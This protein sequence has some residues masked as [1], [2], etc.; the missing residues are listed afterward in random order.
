MPPKKRSSFDVRDLDREHRW[1]DNCASVEIIIHGT[2]LPVPIQGFHVF[3]ELSKVKTNK[4][5]FITEPGD[6]HDFSAMR[7][8]RC[9]CLDS[10]DLKESCCSKLSLLEFVIEK[11]PR[12]QKQILGPNGMLYL[13]DSRPTSKIDVA[14]AESTISKWRQP[15]NAMNDTTYLY[16]QEYYTV[17]IEK[18]D[19][20]RVICI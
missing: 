13:V 17:M 19:H 16:P 14:K 4:S 3:V 18:S 12:E 5:I 15:C 9:P 2:I 7:Q 11:I 8:F 6:E 10:D 1:N 20:V